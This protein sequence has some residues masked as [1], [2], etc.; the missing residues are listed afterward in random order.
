MKNGEVN[1]MFYGRIRHEEL[2]A[3]Y[4]FGSQSF[5]WVY[6]ASVKFARKMLFLHPEIN[7]LVINI[8]DGEILIA[9]SRTGLAIDMPHYY[10][11]IDK[12]NPWRKV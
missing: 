9:V 8:E 2:L 7:C 6:Y 11:E 5:K 12:V 3:E 10:Y 1:N 4:R